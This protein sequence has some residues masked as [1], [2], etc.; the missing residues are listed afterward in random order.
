MSSTTAIDPVDTGERPV[1]GICA[2]TGPVRVGGRDRRVSFVPQ[3]FV[4]RLETAGATAVLLPPL[5][6]VERMLPRLDGLL[7][8]AGPDVDPASYGAVRHPRTERID[9]RRDSAELALIEVAYERGLPV[10]GVCRGLQ[11]LNVFRG[12]TLRQHLPDTL[13]DDRHMPSNS[14]F[15]AQRVRLAPG[16]RLAGCLGGD[17]TVTVPCHHH[18][19]V[20][21]LGTGLVASAWADD[22]TVEAIEAVD[23]PFAIGLQWH[24]E[25]SLDD[26]PFLALARAARPAAARTA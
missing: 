26:R 4:D 8:L 22:G 13:G 14:P 10:L 2:H 5:H 1:I 7:L 25:E 6:D 11:L 20:D 24:A 17:G 21:R 3:E 19:A 12:G 18:Q 9:P 23:H 15:A 16:S